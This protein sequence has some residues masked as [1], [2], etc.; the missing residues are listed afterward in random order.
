MLFPTNV[1]NIILRILVIDNSGNRISGLVFNSVGLA[2]SYS[3]E[4]NSVWVSPILVDGTLGTYIA[5]SW[6]EAGNGVYQYCPPNAVVVPNT[7]TLI[8]VVYGANEAQ[9]DTIEARLSA[10]CGDASSANQTL[11]LAA[12]QSQLGNTVVSI[13]ERGSSGFPRTLRKGDAYSIENGNAIY[14][15][16]YDVDDTEFTTPLL[17]SGTLL[18]VNANT[19]KFALTLV[20]AEI[21]EV[22]IAVEW[23]EVGADGYFLIEYGENALDLATAFITGS[24]TFHQWGIKVQ[25]PTT[26]NPLT[27]SSGFTKVL[28]P[29]VI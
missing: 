11:I 4:S 21:A 24:Q 3:L 12:I 22:Q 16:V 6:K 28:N 20:D 17:G 25:W 15:R 14:V 29:I 7:T 9:E 8:R 19:V 26:L 10:G 13:S 5:N 23:V 1:I 27:V 2:A 18:F